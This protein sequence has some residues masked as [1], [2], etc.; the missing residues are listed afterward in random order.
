MLILFAFAYLKL[1]KS[2]DPKNF[3]SPEKKKIAM[4]ASVDG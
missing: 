3:S 2:I 4:T 1:A